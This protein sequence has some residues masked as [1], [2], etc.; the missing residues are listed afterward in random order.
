MTYLCNRIQRVMGEKAQRR[1]S[2]WGLIS[3][4][5]IENFGRTQQ[6]YDIAGVTILDYLDVYKKFTYTT[7][8]SYRL[9]V[10]AERL[11]SD[12]RNST[13]PNS[14]RSR[15]STPTGGTSSWITTWLTSTWSTVWKRR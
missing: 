5:E 12:R 10:I 2:P 7:R 1:L 9:D 4:K 14:T 3:S 11:N 15:T 6:K 13:T 8:E